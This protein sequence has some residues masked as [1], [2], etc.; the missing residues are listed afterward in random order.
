MRGLVSVRMRV[1]QHIQLYD[2]A[3][4]LIANTHTRT[5]TSGLVVCH[6]LRVFISGEEL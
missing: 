1:L 2:T 5:H 6:L 3:P 4:I